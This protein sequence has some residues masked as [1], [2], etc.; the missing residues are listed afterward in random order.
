MGLAGTGSTALESRDRHEALARKYFSCSIP[1]RTKHD[2]KLFAHE[3]S[4]ANQASFLI[5]FSGIIRALVFSI[6]ITETFALNAFSDRV[7]FK[8]IQ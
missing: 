8:H 3:R 4:K 2:S 1:L 7:N 6:I 5:S